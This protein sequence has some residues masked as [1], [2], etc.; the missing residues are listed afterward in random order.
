M[1]TQL[2][3]MAAGIMAFF[4]S[5]A[6]NTTGSS[7][8]GKTSF[9]AEIGGPGVLFSANYDT[10]FHKSNLG[11]GGRIGIGFVTAYDDRNDTVLNY[12]YYYGGRQ[13]SVLTVPVQVNY[14]FG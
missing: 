6:Q 7:Y 12:N 5:F 4:L 9:F 2:L 11:I 10:R 8:P 1:K 3:F 13:R 14:L